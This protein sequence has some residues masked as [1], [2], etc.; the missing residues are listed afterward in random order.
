MIINLLEFEER[1]NDETHD[2]FQ[3]IPLQNTTGA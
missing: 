3:N 2:P 1:T